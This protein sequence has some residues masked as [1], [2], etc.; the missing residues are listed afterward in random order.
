V[1]VKTF[2]NPKKKIH[3]VEKMNLQNEVLMEE[4]GIPLAKFHLRV[5]KRNADIAPQI[6]NAVAEAGRERR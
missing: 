3:D 1:A 2:G 4:L 5:S 6:D